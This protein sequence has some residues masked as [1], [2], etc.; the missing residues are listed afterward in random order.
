MVHA[1][2][3][4][5]KRVLAINISALKSARRVLW[6]AAIAQRNRAGYSELW[7]VSNETKS[8]KLGWKRISKGGAV[9][10]SVIG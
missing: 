2:G 8:S 5:F 3:V 7:G 10:E 9:R 6:C 1:E 4:M